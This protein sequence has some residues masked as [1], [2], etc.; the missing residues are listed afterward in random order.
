MMSEEKK[1]EKKFRKFINEENMNILYKNKFSVKEYDKIR[2]NIYK[3][4]IMHLKLKQTDTTLEKVKKI[5]SQYAQIVVD[6]D[7][8]L[9]GYY[10]HNKLY[11]ND[12]LP[13]A[14]QITTII[15]ELVH[16]IY[17]E[18]F[19]QIIKQSLNIHD[20]YIIQSF[21]M[22]MLNNSIEN[23]AA[24][25]YISYI[26]EGR[27]TPPECQNFIPFLQLLMQLQ[28]DVE[29][30]KQYFIYGHELSHDIQDI[31]DKIITEELK[32]DIRQQFI[33]DDIEKYNQQLKFD[34]SDERF[35]PEEKLEIM[36]EMVL[37]IFDYFL[38]G[39]GRI[40]ELIENYDIITNKK[41]L[42][43]T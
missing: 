23:R 12:S 33:K 30:S 16:Q 8:D 7:T 20:E 39:D 38:N 41:K 10:I 18:L 22:F 37:F 14:L 40:D 32:E 27:F 42:T 28:I 11:I 19:E 36:N 6:N 29:H 3:S 4:G 25:E 9:Q 35:S 21:I 17:A 2:E 31:L 15:H 43:P 24:T 1:L 34:Y 26:I 5:A 13:E